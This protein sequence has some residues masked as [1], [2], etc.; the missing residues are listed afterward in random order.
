[1]N[2]SEAE[3]SSAAR[4]DIMARWFN[5]FRASAYFERVPE[6]HRDRAWGV[7]NFFATYSL[8]HLGESPGQWSARGLCRFVR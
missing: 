4:G 1:M 7:I 5:G 3:G 8:D 2:A 6:V